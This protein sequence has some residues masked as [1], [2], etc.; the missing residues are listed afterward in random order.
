MPYVPVR[1]INKNE[2]AWDNIPRL[3]MKVVGK[4]NSKDI[5]MNPTHRCMRNDYAY[6]CYNESFLRSH[7]QVEHN[8][9]FNQ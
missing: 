4:P 8:A 9:S 7:Q 1:G 2:K 6:L 5:V 3:L